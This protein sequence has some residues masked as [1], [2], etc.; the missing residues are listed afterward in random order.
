[1]K[2][3]YTKHALEKFALLKRRGW[4][5]SQKQISQT[6]TKPN[7]L[8]KT[9]LGEQAAIKSLDKDHILRVIF[10][11]T[12]GGIIKVITFHPARKGRYEI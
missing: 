6:L 3:I 2:I 11:T 1:M 5:F 9:K 4:K 8:G 10:D 12:Q 7:W